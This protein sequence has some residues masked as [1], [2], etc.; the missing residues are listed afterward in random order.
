MTRFMRANRCGRARGVNGARRAERFGTPES[1]MAGKR[2]PKSH[3]VKWVNIK[4]G[5]Y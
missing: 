4:G 5:W 2:R 3:G 1:Q